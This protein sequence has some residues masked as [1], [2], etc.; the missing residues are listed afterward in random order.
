MS[1]FVVV[2]RFYV[3]LNSES[4]SEGPIRDIQL[5]YT[6]WMQVGRFIVAEHLTMG[7]TDVFSAH[8]Q[9]YSDAI[10]LHSCT[11]MRFDGDFA[12]LVFQLL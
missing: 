12:I 3:D 2:V 8:A 5:L 7:K 10:H 11:E 6:F 9:E 1:V 4:S